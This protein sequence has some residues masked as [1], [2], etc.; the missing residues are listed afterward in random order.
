MRKVKLRIPK[1]YQLWLFCVLGTAWLSGTTFFIL[2]TWF[3]V[4]GEFGLVKHP[5]QFTSLQIHGGA[6][7]LM[8]VSYGFLLG[9]HATYGWNVK[10]RRILGVILVIMP[11]I[12]M[13]TAYLLYYI[14]E[15]DAREIV[16]YV[17]LAIGLFFPVVLTAH[18]LTKTKKK[19]K[20]KDKNRKVYKRKRKE[21]KFTP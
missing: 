2:K 17:H 1:P 6:A 7:F 16:G 13:L 10:P 19:K 21:R 11:A 3:V 8:M 5:W 15:D 20:I 18:I 12:L 9:T 14:A 4:E